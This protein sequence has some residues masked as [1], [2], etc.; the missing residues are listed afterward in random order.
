[1]DNKY[2]S[3]VAMAILTVL[4]L[5]PQLL[6]ES[7]R[8]YYANILVFIIPAMAFVIGYVVLLRFVST[9]M[10]TTL[11]IL[12]LSLL[13]WAIAE[14]LLGTT[15]VDGV[16]EPFTLKSN[17]FYF[18][19]YAAILLAMGSRYKNAKDNLNLTYTALLMFLVSIAAIFS[20][21]YFYSEFNSAFNT[22]VVR[23]TL[24]YLVLDLMIV[25]FSTLYFIYD[26]K[27]AEF[28]L[29]GWVLMSGAF[30]FFGDFFYG[31]LT[32]KGQYS[33]GSLPDILYSLGYASFI[34]A[35]LSL[36]TARSASFKDVEERYFSLFNHTGAPTIMIDKNSTIL[37]TNPQFNNLMGYENEEIINK[38][39]WS[40]M[41]DLKDRKPTVLMLNRMRNVKTLK[42]FTREA[43]VHTKTGET[44]Y[45]SL[46]FSFIPNSEFIV[47]TIFDLTDRKKLEVELKK[48]NEDLQNF[49]FTVSHDLKEPLRNISS[50]ATYLKRDYSDKMDK[51]GVEFLNMLVSSVSTMSQLVD[52]LLTLSRVGR[53]NVDFSFVDFNELINEVVKDIE[54]FIKE[55]NAV[56][57]C[58]NLP[59]ALVQK[60]WMKQVFQNLIQNG[61]KFNDS[62]T[63]TIEIGYTNHNFY[64]EF[65]VKDNGI[66]I[67][68]EYH[69]RIFKL[70]EQLHPREEYG[71]TGAGLAIVKKIVKEHKGDIW[72]DSEEGKGTTIYFTIEKF[73]IGEE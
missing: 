54:K 34:P 57:K 21:L 29:W 71:G 14:Y 18:A 11:G 36:A 35:F 68:K 63:P 43:Q 59:R 22:G 31:M 20:G 72:L 15:K 40:N 51:D 26:N 19:G 6:S 10:K 5:F 37:L 4:I 17:V 28:L 62:P 73:F 7:S 27:G 8:A 1:M 58:S 52:D 39:K 3:I 55:R 13:C 24:I 42:P 32:I 67:P 25:L 16:I 66:G 69:E 30:F 44:H 70:F 56:V 45:T 9:R 46:T 64:Y 2:E 38:M 33:T 50:L 49:T 23:Y 53:K 47:V 48:I 60:T 12:I 61:I 65:S 41:I